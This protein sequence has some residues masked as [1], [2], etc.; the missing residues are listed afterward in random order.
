MSVC[1]GNRCRHRRGNRCACAWAGRTCG[2]YVRQVAR[3]GGSPGH[4]PARMGRSRG[5]CRHHA[6]RSRCLGLHGQQCGF[7]D[8]CG[9]CPAGWLFGRVEARTGRRQFAAREGRHAVRTRARHACAVSPSVGWRRRQLVLRRRWFVQRPARLAGA[10][11]RNAPRLEVRC[12]GVGAAPRA[13]CATAQPA[14]AR[15]GTA[16]VHCS[17]AAMLDIDGHRR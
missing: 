13:G 1:R 6:A 4:P 9:P 11:R 7:P 3:S 8:L 5:A 17:D 15:L 14:P 12:G 2:P 16:C 10:G